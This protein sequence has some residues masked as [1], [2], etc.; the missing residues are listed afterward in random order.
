MAAPSLILFH[1]NNLSSPFPLSSPKRYKNQTLNENSFLNLKKQSLLPN[2]RVK[3]PRTKNPRSAPV[4]VLAAQSNFLKVVQT[5]WKVGKD[6]IETGTNL[7]P[8]SV[9]RPI[10]RVAVTVVVLAVSLFL[11]KSFL[12]TVFFALATMG[13]VY[14][15]FIALNKDQGPKGGGGT[16]LEDP[17]EEARR[18]MEKYK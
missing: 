17:E 8:N 4:V 15:T 6:G 5:V 7:V 16:S 3:N 2:L 1:T 14:F 11:L 10:A 12:S 18:I 9:P 13:L